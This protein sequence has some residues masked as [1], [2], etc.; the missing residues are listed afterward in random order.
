M[1]DASTPEGSAE[2]AAPAESL[3]DQLSRRLK[4]SLDQKSYIEEVLRST[5]KKL[6]DHQERL[7]AASAAQRQAEEQLRTC[8]RDGAGWGGMGRVRAG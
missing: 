1:T 4:T 2:A 3:V 7:E 6:V 8:W 5:E